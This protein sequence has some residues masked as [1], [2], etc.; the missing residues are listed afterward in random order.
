MK[1][2]VML[3]GNG[4]IGRNVTSLWLQR[5][6]E[7]KF[8]VLSRSGKNKLENERITNIAVDV[9][10]ANAVLAVLPEMVDCIIDFVGHP[11]KDAAEFIRANDLPAKAMLEMARAKKVRAMGFIGGA[12]GPKSFTEGKVRLAKMLSDSG[13]PTA[14]VS[15][16]LAYGNGRNDAMSKLVPLL[17]FLGL[18]S[19]KFKPV[20]VDDVSKELVDKLTKI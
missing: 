8:Y 15:P 7:A 5:D 6:L 3:G 12:L 11:A 19:S 1:N 2:I 13:I 9:T 17:K 20:L 14:V 16:T 10:D 18:F 4:Y